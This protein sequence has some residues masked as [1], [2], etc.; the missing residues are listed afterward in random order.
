MKILVIPD[1]LEIRG[2]LETHVATLAKEWAKKGKSNE[3]L[4]YS[5]AI[6]SEFKKELGGTCSLI[7]GW[8]NDKTNYVVKE[9]KPDVIMAHPFSGIQVGIN[10][11]S[12]LE[13]CKLYVTMHG[14][15]TTGLTKEYIS[16]IEKVVCVSN[17]AYE[18]VKCIV[19]EDKL[20]IIYNGIDSKDFF[21]TKPSPIVR[22]KLGLIN[23]NKTIVAITRLSDGKE[24]PIKQLLKIIPDLANKVLG[25]NLVI[26]GGGVCLDEIKSEVE[27]IRKSPNLR[28]AVTGEVSN[29][30]SYMNLADVVLGCDRVAIEA[31]M[32]NKK[33]FYMGLPMWKGLVKNDNFK[34][35]IFSKKGFNNY[36]DDELT[37]HL[38]WMLKHEKEIEEHVDKLQ[39]EIKN[40]CE[41][42]NVSEAYLKMFH[43]LDSKKKELN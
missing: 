5:N 2:G 15:Y 29:V 42:K 20:R 3:V 10:I 9:F 12:K 14:D 7:S 8:S 36:S 16:K 6:S 40:L 11:C 24:L 19:P 41:L 4:I 33:V 17:T 37:L 38:L 39:Y 27:K 23:K 32:C 28:I 35:L 25:L 18:A 34:E 43:N 21:S 13:G 22:N 26:V 1:R 30:R 31:L